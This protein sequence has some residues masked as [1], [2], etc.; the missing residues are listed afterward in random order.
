[1]RLLLA[2]SPMLPP[3][4]EPHATVLQTLALD[5]NI[6]RVFAGNVGQGVAVQTTGDAASGRAGAATA[7][8]S[9]GPGAV[10]GSGLAAGF[11]A[12]KPSRQRAIPAPNPAASSSTCTPTHQASPT[13][14][15]NSS[16]DDDMLDL[17]PPPAAFRPGQEA[18]QGECSPSPLPCTHNQV[19]MSRVAILFLTQ[20]MTGHVKGVHT[21][22]HTIHCPKCMFLAPGTAL[23]FF[24]I[25]QTCCCPVLCI[26]GH[27]AHRDSLL[28]QHPPFQMSSLCGVMRICMVRGPYRCPLPWR[29]TSCVAVSSE[30]K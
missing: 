28:L 13:N 23:V 20:H 6:V 27:Q 21:A 9:A 14:V 7:A 17:L 3:F 16:D 12:G 8:R 29:R 11:L 19:G 18:S 24:F 15:P 5:P 10:F 4:L 25:S 26:Q 22:V 2:P 30:D 1:M